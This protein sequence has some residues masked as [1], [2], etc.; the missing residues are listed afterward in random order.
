[1]TVTVLDA[2]ASLGYSATQYGDDPVDD[3]EYAERIST[4]GMPLPSW[5]AVQARL[6]K[7]SA[8][9]PTD[10][11]EEASRRMQAMFGARNAEHLSILISNAQRDSARLYSIRLGIPGVVQPRNWTDDEVTHAARLHAGDAAIERIRAASN[12]LE[13]LDPIPADFT[14]DKYWK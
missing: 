13:V 4:D 10:V 5:E 14:D 6:A 1:M 9:T 7:L 11:R 8:P 3:K 2:L 12:L